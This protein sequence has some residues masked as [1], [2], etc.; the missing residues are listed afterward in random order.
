[1][2][3]LKTKTIRCEEIGETFEI[4]QLSGLAIEE[5]MEASGIRMYSVI[6]KHGVIKWGDMTTEDVAGATPIKALEELART[7]SEFSGLD[8]VLGEETEKNS[9]SLASSTTD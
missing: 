5:M 2:S 6:A 1:M 7:I 3:Y 4:R 9:L 8:D